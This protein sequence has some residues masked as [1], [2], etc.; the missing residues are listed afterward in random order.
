[1]E[2]PSGVV[3]WSFFDA[4]RSASFARDFI[5]LLSAEWLAACARIVCITKSAF[6]IG[7]SDARS[8]CDRRRQ[9]AHERDKLKLLDRV[10][11]RV[12]T[13]FEDRL[14]IIAR[15]APER[16]SVEFACVVQSRAVIVVSGVST[17]RN[18]R[19]QHDERQLE[20]C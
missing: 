1:L 15:A 7:S 11:S 2:R 14:V 19:A 4:R 18:Q 12:S 17:T 13:E 6:G 20:H 9:A 16:R 5:S 8:R 3:D 10:A